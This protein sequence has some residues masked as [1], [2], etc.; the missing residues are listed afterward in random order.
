[1]TVCFTQIYKPDH[2]ERFNPPATMFWTALVMSICSKGRSFL[3]CHRRRITIPLISCLFEPLFS[4]IYLQ[5]S[6][7][8]V[9]TSAEHFPP[10]LY[11]VHNERRR[12]S[13]RGRDIDELE[14]GVGT[15]AFKRTKSRFP[16]CLATTFLCCFVIS[17]DQRSV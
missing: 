11:E 4:E 16:F 6:R 13:G 1:M 9:G 10:Y 14:D 2:A 3:S 5:K 15:D 12:I 8:H 17:A 7:S